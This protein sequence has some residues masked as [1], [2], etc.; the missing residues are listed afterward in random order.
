MKELEGVCGGCRSIVSFIGLIMD[1]L[2]LVLYI[3][4]KY[5]ILVDL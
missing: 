5:V 4:E 1:S 3:D 2:F